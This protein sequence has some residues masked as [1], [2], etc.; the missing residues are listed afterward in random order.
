MI[1]IEGSFGIAHAVTSS[2]VDHG[3]GHP[4]SNPTCLTGVSWGM[5]E[6]NARTALNTILGLLQGS[7]AWGSGSC[8]L[9]T[10]GKF[11]ME[12]ELCS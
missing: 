1:L 11:L 2:K 10:H 4:S 7:I 3:S 5:K 9:R 12:L 8:G 6:W